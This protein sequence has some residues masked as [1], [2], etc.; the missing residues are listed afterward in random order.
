M[1]RWHVHYL[2]DIYLLSTSFT[3]ETNKTWNA[4]H[5][6]QRLRFHPSCKVRTYDCASRVSLLICTFLKGLIISGYARQRNWNLNYIIYEWNVFRAHIH[7]FKSCDRFALDTYVS[8]II[9]WHNIVLLNIKC[10]SINSTLYFR[11]DLS[12]DSRKHSGKRQ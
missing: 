12:D 6:S 2:P 8:L 5:V 3:F 11:T 10:I 9:R 7:C 4:L 1:L